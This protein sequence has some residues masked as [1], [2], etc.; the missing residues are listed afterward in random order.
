MSGIV[1][2]A[3][4]AAA[5]GALVPVMG[6]ING[7]L[8][9]SLSSVTGAALVLFGIGFALAAIT[10]LVLPGATPAARA[11]TGAEPWQYFGGAIV[12][13][14]VLTVSH[15]V[16]RFGVGNTILFAVCAQII[17]SALIDQF[18]LLGAEVRPI[19][20]LRATGIIVIIVGLVA[21]QLANAM[22][23]PR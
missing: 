19:N 14:Y 22:A 23:D 8:S 4:W 9:R 11:W 16:P 12:V 1:T 7:G 18:G 5:A 21:T 2:N 17:T 15:L 3:I 13:F 20:W 6:I 10:Y